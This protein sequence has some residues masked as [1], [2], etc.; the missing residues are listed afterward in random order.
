MDFAGIGP[1]KDALTTTNDLLEKVLGEL[2]RTNDAQLD[3]VVTELRAVRAS[4]DRLVAQQQ[5]VA[6]PAS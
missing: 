4:V 5:E 2:R 6:A 1:V 3:A